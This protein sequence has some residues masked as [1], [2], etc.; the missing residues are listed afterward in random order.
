M[1]TLRVLVA[2]DEETIRDFI[3]INLRR[4]GY[5]PVE[6][7]DGVEAMRIFEEQQG[8]FQLAL[9][10]VMM[11]NMD[12]FELFRKLR[13]ESENLGIIM[14]TARSQEADKVNGLSLGADDYITKPFSP[15]ELMAR[16]ES[17]SRRVQQSIALTKGNP[18][19]E[20]IT[21]GDFTLN[22]R[23]RTLQKDNVDIELTQM[24]YQIMEY[25]LTHPNQDLSRSE[26]L[27]RVWGENYFGEEKIVDVNIRRLRMKVEDNPSEPVHILT[28][29]GYGYKWIK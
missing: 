18:V 19:A 3:V 22:L 26:I 20:V 17:L 25:F 27:K 13:K 12:G 1:S 21:S 6:A 11:P 28:I 5:D 16:L 23:R 24:E 2:E 4:H 29:W 7:C 9:L 8:D 14:L 10:D 15:G